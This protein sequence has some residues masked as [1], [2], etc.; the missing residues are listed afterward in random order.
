MRGSRPGGNLYTDSS[1]HDGSH[2]NRTFVTTGQ[3]R[4]GF[5][6]ARGTCRE[7]KPVFGGWRSGT[8]EHGSAARDTD[9]R[10]IGGTRSGNLAGPANEAK[11]QQEQKIV[12]ERAQPIENAKT[13]H[14]RGRIQEQPVESGNTSPVQAAPPSPPSR[15]ARRKEQEAVSK[16]ASEADDLFAPQNTD[17]SPEAW[18]ARLI[19]AN[20]VPSNNM[21]TPSTTVET[22]TGGVQTRSVTGEQLERRQ[23]PADSGQFIPPTTQDRS[24]PANEGLSRGGFLKRGEKRLRPVGAGVAGMRGG[25]AR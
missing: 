15:M 20:S 23:Q 14:S 6:S 13:R 17:R 1:K 9:E 3:A 7:R 2:R 12:D 10:I 11:L 4:K 8:V 5:E 24:T 25:D 19:G 21:A 18:M 16:E 22:E